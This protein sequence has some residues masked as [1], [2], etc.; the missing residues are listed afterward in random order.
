[1]GER[2]KKVLCNIREE[3]REEKRKRL[4]RRKRRKPVRKTMLRHLGGGEKGPQSTKGEI[5]M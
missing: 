2:R 3:G 1:M 5:T 4:I